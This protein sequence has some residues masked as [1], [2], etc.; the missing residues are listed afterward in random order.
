MSNAPASYTDF[1]PPDKMIP[2]GFISRTSAAVILL[3]FSSE[4]TP[5]S[6]IRREIS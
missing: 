2:T 4:K 6:R 1:G 5:I 3:L